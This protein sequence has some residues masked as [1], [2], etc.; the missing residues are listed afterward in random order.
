MVY[1]HPKYQIVIKE[2]FDI[3]DRQTMKTL[4]SIN[5]A[6][7]NIVLSQLTSKLYNMI[8]GK[9]DKVDF[10]T[11][12]NTKGDITKLENYLQIFECVDIVEKLLIEYKQE[13]TPTQVIKVAINNIINRK[14]LFEKGFKLNLEFPML[15]YSTLVLSV[16]ASVSFLISSC[17]E[18][19]KDINEDN[20][21]I[22]LDRVATNK[23]KNG[24]LYKN[25]DKFNR[26]CASGE[27]DKALE[28]VHRG[29]MNSL[30][31]IDVLSI[32]GIT[33]LSALALSIIPII[34]ELIYFFYY[35]RVSL[36]DFFEIQAELLQMNIYNLENS[37]TTTNDNKKNVIK[38]QLKTIELFKKVSNKI[39]VDNKQSE[40][41]TN[42]DIS[43][44]KKYK[45][46]EILDGS[47]LDSD[48]SLF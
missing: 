48:N 16:V 26:S 9:I 40:V 42:K 31:G 13:T 27:F 22:I 41:K 38:K 10:G 18:Y 3:S 6:D 47:K 2:Y 4:T 7:Q 33:V 34:R 24:L 25:L 44:D 43:Q 14:E 23:S 21:K 46:N 12:P 20:F 1:L 30:M 5:E 39:A 32:A 19:I 29:G 36:S 45:T 37:N 28:Y 8:I 15:T 11:I 17:I 35:T